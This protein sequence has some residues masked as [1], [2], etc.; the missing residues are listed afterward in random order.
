MKVKVLI[1]AVMLV[2][3]IIGYTVAEDV[4]CNTVKQRIIPYLAGHYLFGVQPISPGYDDF[5]Y[6]Y[7][8][9]M[10]NGYYTNAYLG[11]EGRPPYEGDA[12]AYYQLLVDREDFDTIEDAEDYMIGEHWNSDAARWDPN[13]W[14]WE[15]RDVTLMMK[16]NDAWLSNKDCDGGDLDRH[17]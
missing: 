14:H 8:A 12:S 7:Q 16:W 5:G 15:F 11:K 9:H 13:V 2:M 10:F 6:N 1:L 3:S 17:Y 4:N